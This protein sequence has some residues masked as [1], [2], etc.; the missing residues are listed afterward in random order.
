MLLISQLRDQWLSVLVIVNYWKRKHGLAPD[1]WYWADL[2]LISCGRSWM[3]CYWSWWRIRWA[4]SSRVGVPLR[5]LY[6]RIRIRL[7]RWGIL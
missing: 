1:E 6:L 7:M 5:I 4:L 3:P 2:E